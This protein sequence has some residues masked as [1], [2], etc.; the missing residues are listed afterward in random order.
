MKTSHFSA[1]LLLISIFASFN[2]SCFAT[3]VNINQANANL[4]ANSLSGI[5][6]N[7]ARAIINY[8]NKYGLFAQPNDIIKVRGIG[9]ATYQKNRHD[10]LVR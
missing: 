4:L 1:I 3:P 2:Q 9:R 10:I 6:I 8:R 5:G 7:K